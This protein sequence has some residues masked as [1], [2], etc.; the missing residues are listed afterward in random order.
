MAPK[1]SKEHRRFLAKIFLQN[2]QNFGE[3]FCYEVDSPSSFTPVSTQ[4]SVD[5]LELLGENI[6]FGKYLI[7]LFN[8]CDADR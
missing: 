3:A 5:V 2:L 8:I 6:S 1:W 7:S 4:T